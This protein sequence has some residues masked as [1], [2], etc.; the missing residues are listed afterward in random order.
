MNT[1]GKCKYAKPIPNDLRVR[2]CMFGPP[3]LIAMPISAGPQGVQV[4]ITG[5]RPNVGVG[6]EAP[7]C[8]T[9]GIY[10]LDGL[11]IAQDKA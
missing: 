7:G 8:F 6:D 5:Y 3:Q 2:V 9:A 10:G 1:C 11:E 4:Q